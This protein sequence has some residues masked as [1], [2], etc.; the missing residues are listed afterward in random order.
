MLSSTLILHFFFCPVLHI[1]E[2]ISSSP[3]SPQFL[4][5]H[6]DLCP[7]LRLCISLS[8]YKNSLA[9]QSFPQITSEFIQPTLSSSHSHIHVQVSPVFL[10]LFCGFFHSYSINIL[11]NFLLRPCIPS[12]RTNFC[13]VFFLSEKL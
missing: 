7:Q 1:Q 4:F 9:Q 5:F 13:W 6:L 2:S 3:I 12:I 8:K 11:L 10:I